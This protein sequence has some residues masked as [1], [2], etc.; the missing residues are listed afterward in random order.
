MRA[1]AGAD[2]APQHQGAQK[3]DRWVYPSQ[4]QF[5]NAMQRKGWH[6][7]PSDMPSIVA[8]HNGVN[9]RAW[10]QILKYEVCLQRVGRA[11][12][13]SNALCSLKM[14]RAAGSLSSM[15]DAVAARPAGLAHCSNM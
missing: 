13:C 1:C 6:A 2:E 15:C 8:I 7:D 12:H 3:Q 4:Q 10:H 9:E 14:Q 11:A 5:Y